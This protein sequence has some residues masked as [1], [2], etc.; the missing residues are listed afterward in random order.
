MGDHQECGQCGTLLGSGQTICSSCGWDATT[1]VIQRRRRPAGQLVLAAGWRIVVYGGLVA[2]VVLAFARYRALG[3]G[4]DAATT[5]R[6]I[7]AG[8]GGRA[9]ELVTIHR[10]YE[11]GSA[12]ARFAVGE[13]ATPSFEKGWGDRLE[14]FATM[15]V[16]GW[17]PLLFFGA[18]T[19]TAPASLREMYEVREVDGWGRRYRVE[20]TELERGKDWTQDEQVAADLEKGLKVSFMRKGEPDFERNGQLRLVLTSAGRDG[21]FDTDDDLRMISYIPIDFVV[22]LSRSSLEWQRELE[23]AYERGRHCFRIEGSRWDLLDARIL[24]EHRLE[25]FAG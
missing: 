23:I 7:V 20:T 9:A 10:M 17:I 14:M 4:P 15:N 6:W 2:L 13:L 25:P 11:I 24:A 18:S 12:A 1:A 8:D 22:H 16:R 5:L 19:D 3:P 21:A